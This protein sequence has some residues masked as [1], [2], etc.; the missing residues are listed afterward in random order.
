M[1]STNDTPTVPVS[2]PAALDGVIGQ[3]QD[4]GKTENGQR[5][6]PEPS[7]SASRELD[8]LMAEK[9]MG[10][11]VRRRMYGR[12]EYWFAGPGAGAVQQPGDAQLWSSDGRT[13]GFFA[14]WRPSLD[15]VAALDTLAQVGGRVT[16][17]RVWPAE[18]HV[19]IC[20]ETRWAE[21]LPLAICVT[22]LAVSSPPE[23]VLV[24]AVDPSRFIPQQAKP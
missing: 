12:A 18:W 24:L 23:R 8:A 2:L 21:T 15:V 16:I 9:V 1:S 19:T 5:Q 7:R 14:W 11:T 20:G 3:E 22:L 10:W 4:E 13:F 6:E 17:T